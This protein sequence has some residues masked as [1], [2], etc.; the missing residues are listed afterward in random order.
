MN[1]GKTKEEVGKLQKSGKGCRDILKCLTK[2][3]PQFSYEIL[4][5]SF[6]PK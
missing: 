2:E 4:T 5:P 1:I 6:G 3:I